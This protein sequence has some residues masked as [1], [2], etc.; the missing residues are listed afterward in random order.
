[1]RPAG[2]LTTLLL[3]SSLAGQAWENH[4]E[5]QWQTFET[6][7]FLLHF[8]DGTE[9]S[10]REA[11][12]VA[13]IIYGPVT[14]LYGSRPRSKTHIILKDANDD[15][16][17]IAY[18]YDNKIEI[19]VR[20]LDYDLRGS[21]RWLQDVITH[22]FTHIV[23][24]GTAMKFTR[25]VPGFYFQFVG[26]EREKR[27]DVLYGYPNV[28][29]SYPYPGTNIPPWFAEGVAQYMYAGASYDFWDSHRDMILRDR[30]LNDNLL[31]FVA[32]NSFG[33]RGIGNESAY[34]QGFALVSWLADRFGP[35][36][37]RRISRAMS[38]P[39]SVSI[40]RAMKRATGRAGKELYRE[41]KRDLEGQYGQAMARV[42]ADPVEGD[43][44]I[45]KGVANLHPVWHP[46]ARKF[47]YLSSRDADFFSQTG[48]YIHDLATGQ[49]KKV[50]ARAIGPPAWSLDGDTLYYAAQSKPDKHGSRWYDLYAYDVNAGQERR[51]TH[52]ER[53]TAPVLID[54][55]T[56]AYLTVRDG[57]SNVRRLDLATGAIDTLTHR[58]DG[59]Y[60]HSLSYRSGDSLLVADATQNHGR[61]LYAV[62]LSTGTLRQLPATGGQGGDRRNPAM[63]ARG[64]IISIDASGVHNLYREGGDDPG[65]LTNVTGGAFMPSVNADGEV[66]YSLYKNGRYRIALLQP[67]RIV[68]SEEVGVSP[69]HWQQRPTSPRE[70]PD[71]ALKPRPYKEEMSRMFILPRIM[72]DYETLKPGLYFYANEVLDRMNLFGGASI[73]KLGDTDYFLLTEFRKF[74]PTF[75]ATIFTAQRAVRQDLEYYDYK[76]KNDLKFN[77]MSL[78]AGARQSIVGHRLWMELIHDRYRV[79]LSQILDGDF[80]GEIA[81]DYFVGTT[82]ATRWSYS[83]RRPEY[84]GNMFPLR[85]GDYSV[86]IRA[87]NNGLADSLSIS[88]FATIKPVF[89]PSNTLRLTLK[90]RKFMALVP[91][92]RIG[93]E[94]GGQLGILSNTEVDDFFYFFGGGPPGLRGYTYY[95]ST[96]QGTN[97]MIHSLTLRLPLFIEQHI[98]VG[99]L[100]LQN[101]SIGLVYQVGDGFNGSWINHRYK[102]S[103]GLELRLSGY[104]FYVFPFAI[105]YEVHRP[106]GAGQGD[107][108]Q[109]FTWLFDF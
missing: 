105:S 15:S 28:L 73:N 89:K 11:A 13:E 70:G 62:N 99:Q 95:D 104:N 32:M 60:L 64:M 71:L 93:L 24:M 31:S 102:Q 45:D 50:A 86:E 26:Y 8:H 48:L 34:N 40:S 37:L 98:S 19:W 41:W 46:R 44:L 42:L 90:A 36:V 84:G 72:M 96:A 33:K 5:L 87:E 35:D 22:E 55:V 107:W 100:T 91:S 3:L 23:Q 6:E 78:S 27:E 58:D 1:M 108:R 43:I 18:F 53:A 103:A 88:R 92:R 67:S 49:D 63:T 80:A 59:L 25:A 2:I 54:S 85:G 20:P 38:G 106:V 101:A 109:M 51:L 57:T 12:T 97:L 94:Y 29:A 21:H 9:R 7:H 81:Y 39:A 76:G 47:A 4:P 79:Q 16:N 68:A 56:L 52:G 83:T 69:G 77:L 61:A 17:G 30:V 14:R 10:A 66:V 74:R 65:Y 82:L 75:F